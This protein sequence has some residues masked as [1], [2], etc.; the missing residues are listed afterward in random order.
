MRVF[1]DARM[2]HLGG[3]LTFASNL[4]DALLRGHG[5][6]IDFT[7]LLAKGQPRSSAVARR[8]LTTLSN[9]PAVWIPADAWRLPRLVRQS[10]AELFHSLKRPQMGAMRT[11]KILTLHS[12]YPWLYPEFQSRVERVYWTPLMERAARRADA[13]IVVSETDRRHLLDLLGL[14]P[15]RLF[16]I[17][18]G[19]DS[20][21]RDRPS[22]E[23]VRRARERFGLPERY[24][25]YVGNTFRFKNIP[26]LIRAFRL[27]AREAELPHTLVLVGGAAAGE[28]DV[29]RA[30]AEDPGG[31]PVI[32]TGPVR[33]EV[34]AI[35]AGADLFL[36]PTKYDSF[37]MPVLEAMSVGTPV[38][39]STGGALT[40]VAGNAAVAVDP[41][42]P[43]AM[44]E[45]IVRTLGDADLLD[46]LRVKGLQRVRQ[47]TWERSA[48]MTVDL[49]RRVLEA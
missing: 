25:L 1:I 49:Y 15:E 33:D 46:S 4:G 29:Q 21:F 42:D 16:A 13:V 8:A 9:H 44:A 24:L 3:T 39:I 30:L 10:G 36:F 28:A 38:L 32:R 18:C 23:A 31:P 26:N 14:P 34:P 40:E 6:E 17:P 12:A 48:E 7:V 35:Y 20:R 37:G 2:L 45:G 19:L 43:Q 41:D 22:A 11:R 27:A 47:F 5:A